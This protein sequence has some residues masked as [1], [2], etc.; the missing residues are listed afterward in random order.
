MYGRSTHTFTPY[1]DSFGYDSIEVQRVGDRVAKAANLTLLANSKSWFSINGAKVSVV[2]GKHVVASAGETQSES[3][4]RHVCGSGE[5]VG[6]DDER[7]VG[8][9]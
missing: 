2:I 5:P 9:Y 7:S 8:S 3:I 6:H 4:N 1:G